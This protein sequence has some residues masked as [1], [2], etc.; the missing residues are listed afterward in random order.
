M[1]PC[2]ANCV[3]LD[4]PPPPWARAM[5]KDYFEVTGIIPA[6]FICPVCLR[7]LPL[8]CITP[9]HAPADALDGSVATYACKSCNN[10]M[11][12]EYEQKAIE[13]IRARNEYTLSVPGCI[14]VSAQVRIGEHPGG[15]VDVHFSHLS[16]P[17][18]Y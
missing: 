14:P 15:G 8:S 4:V 1:C 11:N 10:R 18:Q 17:V 5:A 2:G 6:G 13:A 9:A 7:D 12:R 3:Q 16:T